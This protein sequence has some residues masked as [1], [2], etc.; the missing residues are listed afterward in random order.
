MAEERTHS[1]EG[2][3]EIAEQAQAEVPKI[4]A[5]EQRLLREVERL[6]AALATAEAEY[7]RVQAA[8]MRTRRAAITGEPIGPREGGLTE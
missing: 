4:E 3:P 8:N 1:G 7:E 6:R 5:E 2:R